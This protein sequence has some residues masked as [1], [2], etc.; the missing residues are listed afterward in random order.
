MA[1]IHQSTKSYEDW[2]RRQLGRDVVEKD[3]AQKHEKMRESPFAFLA[4]HL[5]ALG[6]NCLRDLSRH[7]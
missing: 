4:R 1:D 7:R 6:G 5:L 2:L 3:L